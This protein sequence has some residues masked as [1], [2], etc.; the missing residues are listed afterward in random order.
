MLYRVPLRD[1][2]LLL[3]PGGGRRGLLEAAIVAF[4]FSCVYLARPLHFGGW[5]MSRRR[6]FGGREGRLAWYWVMSGAWR[7]RAGEGGGGRSG[8]P[9]WLAGWLAVLRSL[10]PVLMSIEMHGS[11]HRMQMW[12]C[13]GPLYVLVMTSRP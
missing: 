13:G 8:L 2:V 11:R 1:Q 4:F 9:G 10:W 7:D 6:F 5:G 3:K 12:C